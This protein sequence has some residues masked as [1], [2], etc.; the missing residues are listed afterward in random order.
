ML[1]DLDNLPNDTAELHGL[2]GQ[3]ANEI[4][5]QAMLIEKLRHQAAGQNTHRFGSKGEGINQLQLRL[6]DEEVAEAAAALAEP[7]EYAVEGVKAKAQAVAR[8]PA[9]C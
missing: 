3:M 2:V 9:A 4:K 1:N 8:A 7:I 5:S 6:E